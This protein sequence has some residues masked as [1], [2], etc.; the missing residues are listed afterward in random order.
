MAETPEVT[1][2]LSGFK[3]RAVV[4][5]F[6]LLVGGATVL[7][8]VSPFGRHDPNT[9]TQGHQ[10]DVAIQ[11]LDDRI[12]DIEFFVET[13]RT[14]LVVCKQ[15]MDKHLESANGKIL[16]YEKALDKHSL[17]IDECLKRTGVRK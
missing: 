7:D 11:A 13:A 12:T 5:G 15:R 6:A 16:M 3:E 2:S 17:Q 1:I 14:A 4:Y 10:R 8:L 9:G